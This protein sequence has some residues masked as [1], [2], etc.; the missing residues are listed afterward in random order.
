MSE[1]ADVATAVI[2]TTDALIV[3]LDSQGR[4]TY[5]NRACEELT[6][7]SRDYALGKR[8]WDFLLPKRFLKPVEAVFQELTADKLPLRFENPWLTRAGEE[9]MIAWSNNVVLDEDGRVVQVIGTG[10]DVTEQRQAEEALRNSAAETDAILRSTPLV[11]FLVDRDRRVKRVN[12]AMERFTGRPAQ[13]LAGLRNG[14]AI[15]CLNSLD[16][17]GG[18]GFGPNCHT[19]SIR[20]AVVRTLETGEKQHQVEATLPV[21]IGDRHQDMHML[22]STAPVH[23]TKED[24]V[25]VCVEDVTKQ[26]RAEEE[27]RRAWELLRGVV[28]LT[29]TAVM[30]YDLDGR[31]TYVN[32]VY[33]RWV[34]KPVNELL[35]G[36]LGDQLPPELRERDWTR[37]RQCIATGKPSSNYV[38]SVQRHGKTMYVKSDMA[39]II[40]PT[41]VV[42]GVQVTA[43]D[44]TELMQAQEH[45]RQ[46]EELYRT[47]DE[48]SNMMVIRYDTKG[49]RIFA[50]QHALRVTGLSAERY[51][52]GHF[53]D[54]V[55]A[56]M[57][58]RIRRK[59]R[60]VVR[61]GKPAYGLTIALV[62]DG[63]S[64]HFST[65]L[66]PIKDASGNVTGVQLTAADITDRVELQ[67][68]NAHLTDVLRAIRNVN[69]LITREHDRD[70]LIRQA[71]N[72]LVETHGFTLAWVILTDEQ[73]RP[74]T[75]EGTFD[76]K[77][78]AAF[79]NAARQEAPP[80]CIGRLLG[81]KDAVVA[82]DVPS[83]HGDCPLAGLYGTPA[84]LVGRLEC[85][86]RLYG[87]LGVY[88]EKEMAHLEEERD[89]FLELVGDIAYALHNLEEEE[90]LKK[91]QEAL[92]QSESLYRSVV[93]ATGAGVARFDLEGRRTFVND[94]FAQRNALPS[95]EPRGVVG[96]LLEGEDRERTVAAFRKCIETALPVSGVITRA[97]IKGR[98]IWSSAQ[99]VPL[100]DAEG[101]V[102][103]AQSTS[104]DITEL[105]EAQERL[106]QSEEL[107][108]SL[109]EA[110]G[111]VVVRIDR[112]G[113]RT[114]VGGDTVSSY[115]RTRQS[116][117][118]GSFGDG[119]LPEDREKALKLLEETFRTGQ[120]VRG[121]VTRQ[122]VGDGLRY[123]SAY[124]EPIKD[125]QGN[126]VQVQTTSFDITDLVETQQA[127]RRSELLYL[128]L[129]E[130]TNASFVRVDRDL[131]LRF[132][133]GA[134]Q[135]VTG[136]SI[137]DFL[138]GKF[139]DTFVPE[140]REMAKARLLEVFATGRPARELLIRNKV[141]DTLIY[142]SCS[143]E[144]IKEI[145][146]NVQQVQ[147]TII[148]ITAQIEAERRRMQAER[149][150][151]LGAMSGGIA[152]DVNNVLAMV[153]LWAN[154][155]QMK[156]QEPV[157]KEALANIIKAASDGAETM[158]RI[159]RF[160]EPKKEHARAPVQLSDIAAESIEFTR[161][162]WKDQSEAKDIYIEVKEQLEPVPEVLG[163]AS[164]LREVVVNLITNAV[165]A[166]PNGGTLTV[167]T[168]AEAGDACLAVIDTGTGIPEEVRTR[169]FDPFFTTKGR[170]GSGLGL[171]AVQGIISA[172][173]GQVEVESMVGKGSTFTIRLPLAPRKTEEGPGMSTE[174]KP[175]DTHHYRILVVEDERLV[176]DAL[177]FILKG[178]GHQV[179]S[180]ESGEKALE[181]FAE[182]EHDIALVDLGLPGRNGY[183]VAQELKRRKPGMPVLLVTGWGGDIDRDRAR[184]IGVDG[185][186][187]KPYEPQELLR[188]ICAA[189]EAAK[190]RKGS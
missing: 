76:G 6:G 111:S 109:V 144:P 103:G 47:L 48:L 190:R 180:A 31:R 71:C 42:E 179:T 34:G 158:R 24:L 164:E 181:A 121:F 174:Q 149:L 186:V 167:R 157:V 128:S 37:F 30:R 176:R 115:G 89:L 116:F 131:N 81:T 83:D 53:G 136:Q 44:I 135:R 175:L 152:H 122:M 32:E 15:R 134:I 170:E 85:Q 168:Y 138:K 43:T 58:R 28:E 63:S 7:Y 173:G 52:A 159:R 33:A 67:R 118:E 127:L 155:A 36:T 120:L 54:L 130:N 166:M 29:D 38:H 150:E 80:S 5:F 55:P 169:I 22:V 123:I 185:V 139:G 87:L 108:R 161:P 93:Q 163:N 66:T 46:S 171:S 182:A 129:L 41:G 77:A 119:L 102:I 189:A 146:G 19:C 104:V 40:G 25:L 132:A 110:T 73:G 100:F 50:N 143:L 86:G 95:T 92:R 113:R 90:A 68:R 12:H 162:M 160:S 16:D 178:Q 1:R 9:R 49:R 78:K 60:E 184:R 165:E 141:G 142:T 177:E 61:T 20:L 172:H 75:V 45:L 91:A 98:T 2:E 10:M 99:F 65:N 11:M 70:R 148:D 105:I 4:I 82:Y 69:Q 112:E 101:K 21:A 13:E 14:E 145:D 35:R 57:Q 107:Y 3:T 117:L 59:F 156:T 27:L 153:I 72:M 88:M 124:W 39:P 79:I 64:K 96:D 188:A 74:T 137:E 106:R 151:A 17:P 187:N 133:M 26:K 51:L 56:D 147:I 8:V 18:C 154:V 94:T 84:S 97:T 62:G 125:Q 114:F 140:D 126:V 183:D 23:T